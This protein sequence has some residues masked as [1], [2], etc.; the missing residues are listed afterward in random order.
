MIIRIEKKIR[1]SFFGCKF[2]IIQNYQ[3]VYI[4]K[5]S[6]NLIDLYTGNK[7]VIRN[8]LKGEQG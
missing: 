6:E 7:I 1:L 5:F 4:N 8:R 2:S 3:I